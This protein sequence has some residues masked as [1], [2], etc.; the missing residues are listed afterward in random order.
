MSTKSGSCGDV[1][2]AKEI[3]MRLQIVTA[4]S[5]VLGASVAHAQSVS[6][7]DLPHAS[8]VSTQQLV[9]GQRPRTFRLFVPPGY[10]GR[11]RLPLVLDLHGSGGNAAGE[12]RNSRLEALAAGERFLVATL[13]AEAGSWNVPVE[14][15]RPD[16]VAYVTDVIDHVSAQ[17]CIDPTR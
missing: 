16:D 7:C 5:I 2:Y 9:S 8:G 3:A 1:L 4:L 6:S 17:A 12:A 15:D 10:D 14:S 11:Q 13:E